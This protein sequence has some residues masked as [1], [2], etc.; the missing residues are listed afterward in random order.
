MLFEEVQ[1]GSQANIWSCEEVHFRVLFEEVQ[2]GSRANCE[3]AYF[4]EAPQ[5]IKSFAP[6]KLEEALDV[7]R[8]DLN[9][10]TS[11]KFSRSR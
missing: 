4:E 9:K 2:L 11:V 5:T 6:A 10:E 7:A 8:G 3:K 1:L